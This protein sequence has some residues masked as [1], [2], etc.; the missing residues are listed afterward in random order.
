MGIPDRSLIDLIVKFRS[1]ISWV[2][3][4]SKGFEML[5]SDSKMGCCCCECNMKLSQNSYSCRSCGGWVC[6]KCIRGYELPVVELGSGGSM[7]IK[8]CKL[9]SGKRGEDV[10]TGRKSGGSSKK[11]HPA[12]SPLESPRESP[13]PPSPPPPPPCFGSSGEG[14]R[15]KS[16]RSDRLAHYLETREYGYSPNA[17]ISSRSMM[18]LSSFSG[19]P[20]PVSVRGSPYR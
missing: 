7:S 17:I 1:W 15:S 11:V 5:T 8:W 6:G 18:M 3:S 10:V 4:D 19:H 9:C 20:S 13:E 2:A 16:I 12:V 14:I